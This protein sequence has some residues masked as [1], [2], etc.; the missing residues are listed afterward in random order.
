M[1]R[2]PHS[3]R[4]QALY[5]ETGLVRGDRPCTRRQALYEETGLAICFGVSRRTSEEKSILHHVGGESFTRH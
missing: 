3:T 5:E 4:R 1:I 2:R